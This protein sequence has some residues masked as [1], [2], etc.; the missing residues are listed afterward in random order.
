MEVLNAV[1][2]GGTGQPV[3]RSEAKVGGRP[4]EWST[5]NKGSMSGH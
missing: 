3:S 4:L 1:G 5:E 2:D